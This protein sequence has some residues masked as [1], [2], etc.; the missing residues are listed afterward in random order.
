MALPLGLSTNTI[1]RN[2]IRQVFSGMLKTAGSSKERLIGRPGATMP[3]PHKSTDQEAAEE[4]LL[5]RL[6][7]LNVERQVEEARGQVRWLRPDYQIPKV[8]RPD[9]M[10]QDEAELIVVAA[11]EKPKWPTDAFEQV[12]IVKDVLSLAPAPA[13]SDEIESV[14]DGRSSS[15]RKGRVGDVLRLLAETGG[16]RATGMEP[17]PRYFVAR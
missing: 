6:V 16:A 14:F 4:E 11:S 2:E 12:R 9:D 1:S 7:A 15:K 8:G 17:E 5:T 10:R 13:L 3:S